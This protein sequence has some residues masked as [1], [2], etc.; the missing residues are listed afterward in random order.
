MYA[1]C[2]NNPVSREDS[3]GEA[4][5]T[6]FDLLSLGSSIIDVIANPYDPWAWAGLAGDVVD[7]AVPFVTGVGELTRAAKVAK[8]TAEVVDDAHAALKTVS[9]L[10]DMVPIDCFVEG[11]LISVE[12][13]YKV[14]EDITAGDYVWAWDEETGE[15]ALKRVLET[16]I[17]STDELVH[18][19]VNGEEIITTPSHPFY[20]PVKGWTN[21]AKLHSGDIL[22]LVNGEYAVVENTQYEI[23]DKP[24][25]IYNFQVEDFHTYYVAESSILVHNTC[26]T[27]ALYQVGAYADIKGVSGLDAHHVGQKAL[28]EKLVKDY[29]PMTAPAIN[30][31]KVGHTISGPNGIV[32]RSMTGIT[33]ARQL[34]ARD[35]L[36]LRRVY[37]DIPNSK[38]KELIELNKKLYPE[39]R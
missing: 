16:Y 35:I 1:Y 34:L 30:V 37:P 19:F 15:I 21:A 7:V 29:D 24:V 39:M 13:G 20:S 27:S 17:N 10:D 8:E 12:D 32:S 18:V 28:M 31:P 3:N 5:D 26:K 2:N 9:K 38:L 14:I 33:T 22:V 11:T 25:A 23:L 4:F 6:V 36:E